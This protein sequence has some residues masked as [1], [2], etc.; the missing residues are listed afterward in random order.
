MSM[1]FPKASLLHCEIKAGA[2]RP[3]S[4]KGESQ[5]ADLKSARKGEGIAAA[6][7]G[8]SYFC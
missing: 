6:V 2:G 4:G 8:C 1:L 7:G 5:C 3:S